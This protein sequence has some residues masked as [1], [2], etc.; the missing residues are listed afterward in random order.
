M[1]SDGR[2]QFTPVLPPSEP[3]R[4]DPPTVEARSV[5]LGDLRRGDALEVD[6]DGSGTFRVFKLAWI[7][8]AQR[9]YVLSRFPEGAVSVDRAQLAAMFDAGRARLAERFSALDRAIESIAS[10]EPDGNPPAAEP[11]EAERLQTA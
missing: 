8:P 6:S 11:A 1:R 10:Q 3:V 7:S 5:M 2:I 9:L 4:V